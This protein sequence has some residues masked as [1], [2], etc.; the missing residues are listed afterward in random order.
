MI[1]L[2]KYSINTSINIYQYYCSN[3]T[4]ILNTYLKYIKY[5]YWYIQ[6]QYLKFIP[7]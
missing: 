2:K 5:N 3:I 7:Q 1:I 6:F 4:I